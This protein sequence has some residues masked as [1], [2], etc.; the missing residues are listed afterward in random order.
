MTRGWVH[1]KRTTLKRK[2]IWSQKIKIQVQT[3]PPP[4]LVPLSKSISLSELVFHRLEK[5]SNIT[6]GIQ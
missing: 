3:L 4:Q 6:G 1:Y 2:G 5:G